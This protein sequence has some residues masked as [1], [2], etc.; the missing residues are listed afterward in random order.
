MTK[1][2]KPTPINRVLRTDDP[3][4]LPARNRDGWSGA[5]K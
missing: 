2:L 5:G 4:T 1:M 3:Y